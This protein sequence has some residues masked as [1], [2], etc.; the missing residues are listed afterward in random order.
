[1]QISVLG[2]DCRAIATAAGLVEMGHEVCCMDDDASLIGLLNRGELPSVEPQ[3]LDQ[4]ER[5]LAR[6]HLW[7]T[8]DFSSAIAYGDVLFLIPSARLTGVA[9]P[10]Q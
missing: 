3:L 10:M 2:S 5:G 8:S 9:P 6:Q 1:M 4:A 7:C